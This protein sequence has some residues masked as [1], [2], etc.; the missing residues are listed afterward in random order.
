MYQLSNTSRSRLA[1]VAHRCVKV[2][3]RALVIS[4]IDF[5]IPQYGG[6]RTAQEQHALFLGGKSKCDGIEKKSTH[7]SGKAFDVY[8]YVDGKASWDE[9]HLT[10]V[11]AAI[12][13]AASELK[14]PLEWGGLWKGFRDMPHFQLGE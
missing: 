7:Q 6:R 13:Q 1:S 9:L 12:L 4:P 3:E 10:T 5:G 11:A 2:I 8:A 14:V